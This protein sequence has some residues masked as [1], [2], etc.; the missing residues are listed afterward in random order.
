MVNFEYSN[1]LAGN[2]MRINGLLS[3][4]PQRY[5]LISEEATYQKPLVGPLPLV[6]FGTPGFSPFNIS[7]PRPYGST[8]TVSQDP[9]SGVNNR[10][11]TEIKATLEFNP[12][13]GWFYLYR[14]RIVQGWN[15][16]PD[17]KTPFSMALTGR[18][19]Q[20]PTGTDLGSFIT[21]TGQRAGE[22][23]NATGLLATN[24]WASEINN[25]DVLTTGPIKWQAEFAAGNSYTGI[26]PVFNDPN[27][28][29]EVYY[30]T[31]DLSLTWNDVVLSG[32]YGENVW[33]PDDYYQVFGDAIDQRFRGALT[34]K[35]GKST[36][37]LNYEGWRDK[38][39]AQYQLFTNTIQTANGNITV[40]APIDQLMTTYTISF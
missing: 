27:R 21:Q 32:G 16:N 13:L 37:A 24:G 23:G 18:I 6:S 9:I 36:I 7:G 22:Q 3:E 38:N 2:L 20:Y 8:V 17:L 19:W 33:G 1:P 5:L 29:P 4:R 26:S 34:W 15:I 35:F 12:G 11:M 30:V 31:E 39:P 25:V 10:E 14:P 28:R 40:A